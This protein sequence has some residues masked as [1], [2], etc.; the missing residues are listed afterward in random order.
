M[1]EVTGEF[2]VQKDLHERSLR[3][4]KLALEVARGLTAAALDKQASEVSIDEIAQEF[5]VEGFNDWPA[6]VAAT[7]R[8]VLATEYG[9]EHL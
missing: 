5:A 6:D 1:T 2:I 7:V 8:N 3:L 4:G 9:Y